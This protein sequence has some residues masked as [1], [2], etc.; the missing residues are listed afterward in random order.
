MEPI[1]QGTKLDCHDDP[2]VTPQFGSRL[3]RIEQH[4]RQKGAAH[5]VNGDHQ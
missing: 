2:Q 4:D 5:D 1:T 3:C